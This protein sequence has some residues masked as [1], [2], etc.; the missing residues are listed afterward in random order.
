MC[1]D[2]LDGEPSSAPSS[3]DASPADPEEPTTY[4]WTLYF[5]AQHHSSLGLHS[6]AVDLLDVALQHTPTLPE[7][8]LFKGRVL[9]RLGDPYGAT[10]RFLMLSGDIGRVCE[11]GGDST[12][13][14][15]LESDIVHVSAIL[16]FSLLR[17]T[18]SRPSRLPRPPPFPAPRRFR[19]SRLPR[20]RARHNRPHRLPSHP[21]HP[22][23]HGRSCAA[24]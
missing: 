16:L 15:V 1:S 4:L 9:K 12:L 3:S 21:P 24:C 23:S 22:R 14:E 13:E 2:S 8:H 5:L 20:G 19:L 18:P 11:A 6:R 17:P 7:F 10:T